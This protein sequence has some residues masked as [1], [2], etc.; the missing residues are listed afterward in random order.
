[1]QIDVLSKIIMVGP[2]QRYVKVEARPRELTIDCSK[3]EEAVLVPAP[4]SL[5]LNLVGT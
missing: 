2:R 5:Y 3:L 4:I 1:M